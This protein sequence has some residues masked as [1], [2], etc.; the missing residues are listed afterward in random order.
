MTMTKPTSEQVTF[1]AAGSGA[2]LRNL[3]DKVREVVSVKD[4]GAVGDGVADDTAAIQ[5]AVNASTQVYLP[6]GTYKC[7][8]IVTLDANSNL[9]GAGRGATRIVRNGTNSASVGVLYAESGSSTTFIE[10]ITIRDMTLDG[11]VATLGFS[12]F[13]HLV[14][15]NGVR[16]V[17]IERVEFVGFRGD[18]LYVGSGVS[19]GIERHN[20]NVTVRDCLFDG[21]NSDNR[22]GISVIDGDGVTIQCNTFRNCSRNN[23]PGP[24]DIEPD[25]NAYHVVRDIDIIDNR[26]ES[27]AGSHAIAVYT[28]AALTSP[29]FG[30]RIIGNDISGAQKLNGLGIFVRTVETLTV[31]SKSMGI[32]IANNAIRDSNA[33]L[34]QPLAIINVRGLLC[35]G[36]TVE[37]GNASYFGNDVSGAPTNFDVVVSRNVFRGS[38]GVD[39]AVIFNSISNLL[40]EANVVDAPANGTS[41]IGMRFV[42]SVGTGQSNNVR[43]IN[44]TFVKGG[45]QTIS[46]GVFSHTLDRTTNTEMGTRVI[47]GSLTDQFLAD[48]GRSELYST[49]TWTP[50]ITVSGLTMTYSSQVGTW[51]RIGNLV[52]VSFRAGLSGTSGSPSGGV[53]ITNLPFPASSSLATGA[54]SSELTYSNV[55]IPVGYLSIVGIINPGSSTMLVR[56]QGDNTANTS[57]LGSSLL[58]NSEFAGSFIYQI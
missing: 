23:M 58:S 24:I 18:G 9:F 50:D 43:C 31:A 2:T 47:G 20:V 53:S 55:D 34:I 15:L 52:V 7:D 8:G 27:Y 57:L 49:G 30:V 26:I 48:Y 13:R 35:D 39:G 51:T 19:G 12:A 4:F 37:G 42:C 38:G 56:V 5:A 33:V 17:V 25:A 54:Y 22:N 36:N 40:I 3:V 6:A 10:N 46:F 11:Q 28:P 14:S 45:S 16:N 41:T 29:V 44:N 1:T 21:V 32:V